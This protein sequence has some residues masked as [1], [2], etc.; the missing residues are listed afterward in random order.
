HPRPVRGSRAF[1]ERWTMRLSTSERP[2]SD[3]LPF[4]GRRSRAGAVIL[5]VGALMVALYSVVFTL[6]MAQEGGGHSWATAVY[7]TITTMSTLGYGDITFDSDA[8][9]LFSLRSEEHTSELQSRFEL[10]C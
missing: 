9:R 7:W 3:R 10:V 5:A 2:H 8:G 1:V 4:R 6:L